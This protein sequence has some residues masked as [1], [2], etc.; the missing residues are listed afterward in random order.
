V[1][2][3]EKEDRREKERVRITDG[4]KIARNGIPLTVPFAV[5]VTKSIKRRKKEQ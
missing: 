5:H 4:K 2:E 3:N 1:E